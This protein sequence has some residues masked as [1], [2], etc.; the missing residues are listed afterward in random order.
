MSN[1]I[2]KKTDSQKLPLIQTEVEY[3]GQNY[4]Y[5][6]IPETDYQQMQPC[7]YVSAVVFNDEGQILVMLEKGQYRIPGG[8]PEAADKDPMRTILREVQDEVDVVMGGR[9]QLI[10]GFRVQNLTGP[11]KPPFY[12]LVYYGEACSFLPR[13][14]SIEENE[15]FDYHFVPATELNSTIGWKETGAAM[16]QAAL[17]VRSQI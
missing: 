4:L 9:I 1:E 17:K 8:G 2:P 11:S 16:L 12:H 6:W 7:D 15:I 14:A 5:T 13:K 10:G 3:D